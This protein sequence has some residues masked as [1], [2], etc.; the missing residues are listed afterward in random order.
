MLSTINKQNKIERIK[1][2]ALS[3][4]II[5]HTFCQLVIGLCYIITYLHKH[6]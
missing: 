3:Y 6:K 5:F 1:E 2:Y 4:I